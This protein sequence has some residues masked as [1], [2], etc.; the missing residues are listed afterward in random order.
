[1]THK[2]HRYQRAHQRVDKSRLYSLEEAVE[3]VKSMESVNF[4]ETVECAVQLGIDPRH[5]DQQV[6]GAIALPHGTGQS[7]T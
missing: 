3:V 7:R 5:S 2:S 4:D 6:R 1:M